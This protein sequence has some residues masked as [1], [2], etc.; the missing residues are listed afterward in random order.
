MEDHFEKIEALIAA[1]K[2]GDLDAVLDLVADDVVYHYHVGSRPLR[3]KEALR[4]FLERFGRDQKEIRWRIVHHA[5][6][7][8]L[9]LVEGVDGGEIHRWRDY[10]DLGLIAR[11]ESGE[12]LPDW[13]EELVR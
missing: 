4:R 10:F 1:W 3:G 12:P 2:R 11:A 9:L 5:Q 8:D 6:S 13:L 7:G